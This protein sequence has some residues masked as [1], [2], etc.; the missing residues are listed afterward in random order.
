MTAVFLKASDIANG[1]VLLALPALLANGLLTHTKKRFSLPK[2]FYGIQHLFTT[3]AFIVLLRIKSIEAIQYL[4]PGELGKVIGSDRVPEIKTIRRKLGILSGQ[5]KADLW[6]SDLSKDWLRSDGGLS[7]LLYIDGHVR[8]YHGKKTKLPKRYV[9][10]EKLCLRGMTDYW[11]NN[12]LGQPYFVV[13]T[14][15]NSGMLSILREEIIPR[16]LRE[17]PYKP[18][19]EELDKDPEL[20]VCSIV[21]DREGY[22]PEF[23][24]E[25][26]NAHRVAC[27]TYKKYPGGDWDKEK[28][29]VYDTRLYGGEIVR[30]MI[31]E[32]ETLLGNTLVVREIRRLSDD[33]H[34]TAIITTNRKAEIQDI[35]ANM[36]A[37]WSQENFFKYMQEHFGIDR[38]I[39]YE[40][41]PMDATTRVVNPE[42]RRL[43]IDKRSVR[44]KLGRKLSQFGALTLELSDERVKE[45]DARFQRCLLKKSELGETVEFYK[46]QLEAL[47]RKQT[48]VDTHIPMARL[49][50]DEKYSSLA[51]EK[52]HIMDMIKMIVY[53]AETA[54]AVLIEPDLTRRKE[55]RA[56]LRQIFS[57]EIDLDPDEENHVLNVCLHSMSNERSNKIVSTLCEKLNETETVFPGTDMR[58]IYKLVSP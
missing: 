4:S 32:K 36:F 26:W 18:T 8:V 50:E 3:L 52:K 44:Q 34:Q 49:P 48:G 57:T 46:K 5:K 24:R 16:I 53:R 45:D 47:K 22:S 54:M 33:G 41:T 21:F 19:Q 9:S 35:A 37:R 15:Q 31:G 25:M 6:S 27:Y 43:E 29:R 51:I 23:M 20:S 38:L 58:I 11:L 2:G 55:T 13:S 39:E 14:A 28:F 12:A 56:L 30:M 7:G 1:G 40:T 42:Y 17:L 10:R